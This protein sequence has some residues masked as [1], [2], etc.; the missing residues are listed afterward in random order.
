MYFY[1]Y[2]YINL[3][4]WYYAA[5]GQENLLW[6]SAFI[7]LTWEFNSKFRSLKQKFKN[8]VDYSWLLKRFC[9]CSYT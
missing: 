3:P 1:I 8:T 5:P 7:L 2:V 6:L 9:C 4:I